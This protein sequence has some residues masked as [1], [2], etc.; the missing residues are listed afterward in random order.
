[1]S[2][3]PVDKVNFADPNYDAF[4]RLRTS[5][6]TTIFESMAYYGDEPE[7]YS[8]ATTGS[9][10]ATHLPNESTWALAC[11]S[12]ALDSVQAQSHNYMHYHPGKSH[13][14]LMTGIFEPRTNVDARVGVF[15]DNDGAFFEMV[16]TEIGVVIRT[17]TSGSPVNGR[18][19]QAN[20]NMDKLDGTGTSGITLDPTKAQV[21]VIDLQWLGAGRVR[22]GFN[23]D[24]KNVYCHEALNANNLDIVYMM[25]LELPLRYEIAN[26]A[27]T[28]ATTTLKQICSTV[29]SEGG[30][31]DRGLPRTW[32]TGNVAMTVPPTTAAPMVS[33]RMTNP[34]QGKY[35]KSSAQLTDVQTIAKT[36]A[37]PVLITFIKNA[38]LTTPSWQAWNNTVMDY[39]ISSASYTGGIELYSVMMSGKNAAA[40]TKN[41]DVR[42]HHDDI[43]TV[44]ALALDAGVDVWGALNWRMIL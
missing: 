19:A 18:I 39:D 38:V 42:L 41:E 17:S 24:G 1:M 34:Y 43:I 13:L 23:I 3:I 32:N 35:N 6:A 26:T 33:F 9:A 10:S 21:F 2:H 40:V 11:G 20:W 27:V 44:T 29:I 37:R 28:G 16:G 30:A 36:D 4:A 14:V 25:T 12:G 31:E 15:D 22:F 7:A 5:Q 8:Y